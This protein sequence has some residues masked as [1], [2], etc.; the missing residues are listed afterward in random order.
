[1]FEGISTTQIII[2]IALHVLF[3][4]VVAGMILWKIKKYYVKEEISG[5]IVW[6]LKGSSER[7]IKTLAIYAFFTCFYISKFF[8]A[9]DIFRVITTSVIVVEMIFMAFLATRPQKICVNGLITQQGFTEW[10]MVRKV[11]E[12]EKAGTVLIKL[13][14]QTDNEIQIYCQEEEKDKV[15]K[16]IWERIDVFNA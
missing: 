4:G 1:M 9:S 10:A 3:I 16:Y 14:R 7:Y 15:E 11:M 5:D 8:T 6:V 2:L 12:S 13:K